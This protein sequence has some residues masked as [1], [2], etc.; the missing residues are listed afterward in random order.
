MPFDPET[1]KHKRTLQW[2]HQFADTLALD[3]P[4]IMEIIH[5]LVNTMYPIMLKLSP[6][7]CGLRV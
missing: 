5:E 3:Q 7:Y 1:P 6:M 4:H 2:Y